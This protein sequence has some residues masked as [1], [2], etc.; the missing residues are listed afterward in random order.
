MDKHLWVE[1]FVSH[2]RRLDG[3]IGVELLRTLGE[4]FW[5]FAKNSSPRAAARALYEDR[6]TGGMAAS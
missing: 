4:D 1:Q 5:S 6:A 3:R 2:L